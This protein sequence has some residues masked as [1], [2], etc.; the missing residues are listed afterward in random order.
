MSRTEIRLRAR[1]RRLA[2]IAAVA[3]V[4]LVSTLLL[5]TLG[6]GA[7]ALLHGAVNA[8]VARQTTDA[9]I[10]AFPAVFYLLG[11]WHARSA[12]AALADGGLFADAAAA[13]LDRVGKALAAGAFVGVAI[14]PTLSKF[15]GDDPGYVLAFDIGAAVLGVLGLVLVLFADLFRRAGRLQSE[16]REII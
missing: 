1:S 11:L 12:L 8:E 2:T 5:E 14:I 6:P 4:F 9:A 16:M 3:F 7:V 15:F 13:A 10:A